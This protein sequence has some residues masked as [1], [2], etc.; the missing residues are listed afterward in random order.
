M[1]VALTTLSDFY[2]GGLLPVCGAAR[3]SALIYMSIIM[4]LC[5]MNDP[6]VRALVHDKH[7]W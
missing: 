2:V 1:E 5:G 3:P 7:D 4:W 6:T